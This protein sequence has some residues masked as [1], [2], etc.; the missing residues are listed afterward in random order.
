MTPPH[1]GIPIF[2]TQA[3]T[4]VVPGNYT[5]ILL[6]VVDKVGTNNN[7][8]HFYVPVDDEHT[9][10]LTYG[11]TNHDFAKMVYRWL[12]LMEGDFHIPDRTNEMSLAWSHLIETVAVEGVVNK[13]IANAVELSRT[14]WNGSLVKSGNTIGPFDNN[15]IALGPYTF[16]IQVQQINYYPLT[17]WDDVTANWVTVRPHLNVKSEWRSTPLC[18]MHKSSMYLGD[19]VFHQGGLSHAT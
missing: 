11:D 16:G 5:S 9:M 19:G 15:G 10:D 4:A 17:K 13:A 1:A 14:R 6:A 18:Q 7:N 2:L 8:E 3:C 12:G